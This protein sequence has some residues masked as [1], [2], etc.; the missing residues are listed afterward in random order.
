M[1]YLKISQGFC[2]SGEEFF[3]SSSSHLM[4]N[5]TWAQHGGERLQVS[6]FCLQTFI[7]FIP[8]VNLHSPS[9]PP[10]Y[11]MAPTLKA[12]WFSFY[13][14][15]LGVGHCLAVIDA[16]E[17][18]GG[19]KCFKFRVSIDKFLLFLLMPTLT[20]CNAWYFCVY[21]LSCFS[22]V[23]PCATLGN[24]AHQAPLSKGFSRQEYWSG[25][26]FPSPG[27]L[28]DPGITGNLH[29]LH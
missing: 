14:K 15:E 1:A 23:Q 27:D 8:Y 24:A 21:M 18:A 7:I 19:S 3:S 28:P 26:P 16:G 5:V 13:K 4:I 12:L 9:H 17:S 29:L 20:I 25:L 11:L 22:H 2:F 10:L 6:S